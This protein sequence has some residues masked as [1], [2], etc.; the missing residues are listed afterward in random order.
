MVD[1]VW[2]NFLEIGVDFIDEDHRALLETMQQAKNAVEAK[3]YDECEKLLDVLIQDAARHFENEEQYLKETKY[4]GLETHIAYHKELIIKAEATRKICENIDSDN[5]LKECF[6]SLANFLI[7]D[8]LRGD[9]GFKS[10]LEYEGY[11]KS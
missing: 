10:Y 4:P 11:I 3:N 6:D 2:H 9:I 5:R 8:I 7:D 1:L